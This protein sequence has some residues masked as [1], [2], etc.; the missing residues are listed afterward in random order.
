MPWCWRLL[1]ILYPCCSFFSSLVHD[2]MFLLLSSSLKTI[3]CS[4]VLTHSLLLELLHPPLSSARAVGLAPVG[5]L[6]WALQQIC[7]ARP[8]SGKSPTSQLCTVLSERG[9]GVPTLLGRSRWPHLGMSVTA[10][11]CLP[12]VQWPCSP[13]WGL[14]LEEQSPVNVELRRWKEL[15]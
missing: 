15:F 8:G 1:H 5:R 7:P 10:V 13:S 4:S 12:E 3:P 2:G 14:S 9:P 6:C 11:I